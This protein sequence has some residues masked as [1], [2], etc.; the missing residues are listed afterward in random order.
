M[1][2]T[3]HL[4]ACVV[5]KQKTRKQ[6]VHREFGDGVTS[7]AAIKSPPLPA[8]KSDDVPSSSTP[9]PEGSDETLMARICDGD[10][11]AFAFLFRRCA[12]VVRSVA[13]RVLRDDSEADDLL[14]EVFLTVF[15][16]CQLFDSAK[17]TVSS[18]IMHITYCRAIDRRRRWLLSL[19]GFGRG[20]KQIRIT[21]PRSSASPTQRVS[22]K[23]DL[24]IRATQLLFCAFFH[25]AQRSLCAAAILR[26]A[27]ADIVQA[28]RS[29]L[30]ARW[31]AAGRP[32]NGWVFPSRSAC[33]HFESNTAKNQHGRAL[34]RVNQE[35]AE[36]GRPRL[37]P[38]EPYVLRHTA[39]T[40]LGESG[41]DV[42]TLA[43]IAGHS[44]IQI[45]M[46]YV[47]PQ[48]EAIQR[49]FDNVATAGRDK[50]RDSA[51]IRLSKA[52]TK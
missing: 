16:K 15:R 21:C 50:I 40:R 22:L 30:L 35:A 34:K 33:G 41:C 27:A 14:Q 18:W 48:A 44:N 25:F 28:V 38:F 46:R 3:P 9:V 49:A 32:E 11:Q 29:A 6:D 52:R 42:F 26:R 17:G 37:Q 23:P 36:Q 43:R 51:K 1:R 10:R 39:L 5:R 13:C 45:T 4:L 47:H 20:F 31:E 24:L 19:C 7:S 8:P 12:R 2:T